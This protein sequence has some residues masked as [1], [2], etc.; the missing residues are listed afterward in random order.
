[1]VGVMEVFNQFYQGVSPLKKMAR[2][3]GMKLMDHLPD[4]K[5]N[6]LLHAMGNESDLPELCQVG[7]QEREP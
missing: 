4:M 6:F 1:M 7:Y 2:S 3:V 5:E